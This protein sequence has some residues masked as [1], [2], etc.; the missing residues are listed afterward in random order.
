MNIEEI[1]DKLKVEV[2]KIKFKDLEAVE[3]DGYEE[4]I[5]YLPDWIM[6]IF[7][8]DV[9]FQEYADEEGDIT[10][11]K[12]F[13]CGNAAVITCLDIW[14]V[15]DSNRKT[16]DFRVEFSRKTHTFEMS[17]DYS[18]NELRKIKRRTRK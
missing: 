12:S 2:E 14:K 13:S 3:I 10:I 16:L 5:E 9:V 8:D 17:F 11:Y 15:G 6:E 7:E 1:K 4:Y 18:D